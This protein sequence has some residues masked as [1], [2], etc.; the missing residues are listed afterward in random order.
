MRQNAL[1]SLASLYAPEAAQPPGGQAHP[2]KLVTLLN[3]L[4]QDIIT[5]LLVVFDHA[6]FM[7]EIQPTNVATSIST[8]LLC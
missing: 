1:A 5:A 2:G 7:T 3:I 4:N 6:Q 8:C